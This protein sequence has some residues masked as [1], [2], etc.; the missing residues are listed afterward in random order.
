MWNIRTLDR[1]RHFEAAIIDLI[2]EKDAAEFW[3]LYHD[4]FLTETDVKA[5]KSWG[6]NSLRVA[7]L[8]S[9]LQPRQDQPD[10]PPYKYSEYGFQ[11]L[12]SLVTWCE[13]YQV[14][15]IWDMHGAP[16]GQNAE[17][18]SDSDGE[19]RLW[20]EKEKYWPRCIDLWQ[21]IA[22][23]YK[24]HDC[25][26]GYDLL[27]EPLLRR[28]EGLSTQLL[29][30]L[31]VLITEAIRTVDTEGI[32]FIEGDDWAQ[33]FLPLEPL[34]WDPHLVIAFHSYPPTDTQSGLQ[35][36]DELRQKYNIPL[37][38]GETGEQGPPFTRNRRSTNFLE[39][40]NVGWSWWTHKKFTR[41]TQPWSILP[42]EG[43]TKIIDYWKG[44]DPRPTKD[45]AREWLFDQAVKTNSEFCEFLPDMV[46]NLHPLNPEKYYS[47]LDTIAPSIIFHPE[48][49]QV[50]YG[51]P[52]VFEVRASGLPLHYQWYRDGKII[53]WENSFR[54]TFMKPGEADD[55]SIFSVKISN[56]AGSV[57]SRS[58]V[59]SVMPYNGPAIPYSVLS[60]KIDGSADAL[61]SA[62]PETALKKYIFKPNL[63]ASDLSA[64]YKIIWTDQGL[65]ILVNVTDEYLV[66]KADID[67]EIDGIEIYIDADN[68]KSPEY[69]QNDF[70]LRYSY[71]SSGLT[72][73]IGELKGACAAAQSITRDGYLMELM[74]PWDAVLG[75]GR[76]GQFLG[77][78]IH[79]NDNDGKGR[80]SKLTWYA[81]RDNAYQSPASFGTIRLNK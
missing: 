51:N 21:T 32:I 8:A 27:N 77:L 55:G 52:A 7:L 73:S 5:M 34:D 79:V 50:S 60:P 20:T 49:S 66:K 33:D 57:L 61:W 26:I 3:K 74:I 4:N 78:D 80:D 2:G 23:R 25:I 76:T 38:H 47:G 24:N 75:S 71:A 29:R 37:W 17:N 72:T 46:Q 9:M 68:S 35:R 28:Y 70:Q 63:S 36:W 59:L 64:W 62:I 31:Y 44:S 67:Y 11:Y 43:F 22:E 18:I 12:D 13:K 54:Y 41:M 53:R 1:P 30:E 14:G 6:V 45:Q 65:F 39:N 58:A 40:A 48:D 10:G 69:G 81:E 42:T 56:S 16:G 15:V 19:A